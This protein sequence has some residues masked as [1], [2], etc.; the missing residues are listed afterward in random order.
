MKVKTVIFK[1]KKNVYINV[2]GE[3]VVSKKDLKV[4]GKTLIKDINAYDWI[5]DN[6]DI[7]H[8]TK[9][10]YGVVGY[11]YSSFYNRLSGY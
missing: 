9:N 6:L 11:M 1:D 8:Y 10:K 5:I 3:K 4:N 7:S 2:L